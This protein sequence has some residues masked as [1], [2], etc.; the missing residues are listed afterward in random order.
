MIV[1]PTLIDVLENTAFLKQ[2]WSPTVMLFWLLCAGGCEFT[3]HTVIP[4]MKTSAEKPRSQ[5]VKKEKPSNKKGKVSSWS[6]EAI[7][8]VFVSFWCG[9]VAALTRNSSSVEVDIMEYQMSYQ[10][11]RFHFCL[12]LDSYNVHLNNPL[13]LWVSWSEKER[14]NQPECHF[15]GSNGYGSL[16]DPKHGLPILNMITVPT[17][18]SFLLNGLQKDNHH[19][20]KRTPSH[21]M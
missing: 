7:E 12:V 1:H 18:L 6:I 15:C 3:S 11:K 13:K 2:V 9:T 19:S 14:I 21:I 16:M 10:K 5:K 8:S 17:P 20:L 4:L